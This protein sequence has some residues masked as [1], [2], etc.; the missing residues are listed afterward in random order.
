MNTA[1][2][3]RLGRLMRNADRRAIIVPIDH[4]LTLGPIAGIESVS[5]MA[6]FITH[7]RID[8]VIAH[9]GILSRLA[10]RDLLSGKGVILHVNGMSSL[11]ETPDNKEILTGVDTALRLGADAISLQVNFTG[12]NDSANLRMLG[13]TVDEA[14]RLGLPVLTML[15]DKVESKDAEAGAR[16]LRQLLRAAIELGSDAIKIGFVERLELALADVHED[17]HV[18]VAGG[19]VASDAFVLKQIASAL[20]LGAAGACIGRNVFA[21]PDAGAFLEKL[22]KTVHGGARPV[23]ASGEYLHAF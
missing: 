11:A 2:K 10:E 21:K 7:P 4:G 19:A 6:E 5:Q 20:A 3:I 23:S 18:F 22:G 13:K 16:R 12:R 9:K 8:A 17:A 14:S 15:Y 1:K